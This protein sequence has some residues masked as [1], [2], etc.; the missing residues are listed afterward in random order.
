M[1][2]QPA[3]ENP[4]VAVE[5]RPG[6]IQAALC[7][8]GDK[9]SPLLISLLVESGKT[10]G[11]LETDLVGISPKTLSERLARLISLKVVDKHMYNEHPPRYRY[12]LT[13]KGQEFETI[14]KA[15]ATWGDKYHE[16]V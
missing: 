8:L 2:S 6:C 9:W 15:M 7:I 3:P 16:V 11:E 4:L 1:T 12:E 14:L 10:F 5:N 13:K